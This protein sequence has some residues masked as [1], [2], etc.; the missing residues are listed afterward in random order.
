M[1]LPF[2]AVQDLDGS[3]F[4]WSASLPSSRV[5]LLRVTDTY[6]YGEDGTVGMVLGR[7]MFADTG[8]DASRSAATRAVMESAMVPATL[9]PQT[10]V[11]WELGASEGE[12][13]FRRPAVADAESVTVRIDRDGRAREVEA[14]RWF[15]EK[16][17]SGRLIPFRCVFG[18][19]RAFAGIRVPETLT[20]GWVTDEF[21]PFYWARIT[22]LAAVSG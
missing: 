5:G 2:T 22:G 16:G 7:R 14:L 4:R 9:L 15:V 21:R 17:Q 19:E 11:V 1:R 12:I 8:A 6:G 20:A 10:G 18:G 13:R 3:S